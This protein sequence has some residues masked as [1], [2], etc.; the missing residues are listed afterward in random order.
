MVAPQPFFRARGTPFSILHR[1]RALT[2]LGCSVTLV[3]YPFGDTLEMEGLRIVRCRRLPGITDV[4]IGPSL[5]KLLMDIPLLFET[6]SQ[7]RRGN[8]DLLHSHEEAAFFCT[9]LARRYSLPHVYDMHS[10]LPRQFENFKRYNFG[11]FRTS[12]ERMEQ[13]TLGSAAGVITICD[14]LGLIVK[15]ASPET[16]HATIENTGDDSRVFPVLKHQRQEFVALAGKRLILYTGTFEAYQGIQMLLEALA[17]IC[18]DFPDIHLL[19]AGGAQYDVQHMVARA[20]DLGLTNRV[21][22]VGTVHPSVIPDYMERA[23]LLVSP[24]I[25]GTNTPLKLYGYLRSGVPLVATNI[26]SH[27]QCLDEKIAE[28]VEPSAT[29]LAQGISRLL[30]NPE[31]ARQMGRAARHHA[32]QSWSDRSYIDKVCALYQKVI[33]REINSAS[34]ADISSLDSSR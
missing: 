7:L 8:F 32:E 27:T 2:S 5:P 21:T 25:S 11:M 19:L 16:V 34:E 20:E 28:L 9:G 33:D 31:Y 17:S 13:Y 26:L 24:R 22:F 14:D 29:G 30:V 4:R 15:K 12:F 3:T 18:L 23:E 6:A 1:I 10:S